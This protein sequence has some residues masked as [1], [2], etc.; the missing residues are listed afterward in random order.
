MLTSWVRCLNQ[1]VACS[2]HGERRLL[3]GR[4][5]RHEPHR[6]PRH[7]LADRLGIIGVG[8]TA[9]DVGLH[10]GRRHETNIVPERNQLARPV[11]RRPARLHADQASRQLGEE[12]QHLSPPQ[13]LAHHRFAGGINSMNLENA[14]GQIEAD[15]GN[16][17]RGWLPSSWW[18][19][20]STPWHS[21]A[22][23]GSYP[24]HLLWSNG[25]R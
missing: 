11:M 21:D 8:L 13:R 3:F 14:L 5:Y 19:T 17:H 15:R 7:R 20:A 24:P 6:R 1:Q 25:L 10:I 9:L 2:M 16:L 23:S 4:L 22:V 18:L 12:R